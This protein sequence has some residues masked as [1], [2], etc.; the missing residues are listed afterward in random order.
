LLSIEE[1]TD[2][3]NQRESKVFSISQFWP[4]DNAG[5]VFNPTCTNT[6]NSEKF[7]STQQRLIQARNKTEIT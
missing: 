4:Q 1:L 3:S 2:T 6:N 7:P 5:N